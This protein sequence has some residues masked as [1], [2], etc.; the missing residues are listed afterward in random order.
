MDV[1]IDFPTT[2]NPLDIFETAVLASMARDGK[3]SKHPAGAYF[4]RVPVDSITHLSAIPYQQAEDIG[5]LK[6]DFLHL[7]VLDVFENKQEIRAL[8]KKEPD[9]LMLQNPSIVPKLFQMSKHH[10][11]LFRLKPKTVLELADAIALIRPGKK[12]LVDKYLTNKKEVRKILYMKTGN[13]KYAF[14]KSHAIAYSLTIVLQL[15]LI[16]AGII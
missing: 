7:S 13:D 10:D 12:V 9:W 4:Q 3:L 14:K 2:F 15:H 1:D 11:L 8:L 5:Y 16:K 6:I